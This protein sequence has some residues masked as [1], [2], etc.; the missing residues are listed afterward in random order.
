MKAKVFAL[1]AT[2]LF[3]VSALAASGAACCKPGSACCRPNASC[4]PSNHTSSPQC[5]GDCCGRK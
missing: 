2:S 4:C 3:T 5:T 1:I